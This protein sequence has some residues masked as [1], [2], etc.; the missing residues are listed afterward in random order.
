M[1]DLAREK[2]NAQEKDDYNL[3]P[4][5]YPLVMDAPFS[6]ADEKHV[7]SISKVLPEIAEQ[8]IMVVMEKDWTFAQT[9]MEDRVGNKYRLVKGSETLT[10][11][12]TL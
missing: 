4:E 3:E 6:K 12:K 10:T 9:E 5:S 7:S 11:I 8:V 2:I 1:V